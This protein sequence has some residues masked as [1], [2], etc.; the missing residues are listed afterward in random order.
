MSLRSTSKQENGYLKALVPV[1]PV[2]V[3]RVGGPYCSG[4]EKKSRVK[5]DLNAKASHADI[6]SLDCLA[7][8][9]WLLKAAVRLILNI[10]FGHHFVF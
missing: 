3:P 9:G 5:E 4:F 1:A 8:N 10:L 6:A 2:K 7:V